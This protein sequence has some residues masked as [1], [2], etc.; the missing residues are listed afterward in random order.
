MTAPLTLDQIEDAE[1]GRHTPGPWKFTP[2]GAGW[3][4]TREDVFVVG[5]GIAAVTPSN[6]ADEDQCLANAQLIAASPDLLDACDFA[7]SILEA[8]GNGKGDA[9]NACRAAIAKARA[10]GGGNRESGR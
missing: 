8:L 7:L 10:I 5:H 6:A 3:L 9:A 1:R 2:R 4:I